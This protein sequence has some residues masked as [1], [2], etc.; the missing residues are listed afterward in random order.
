MG[1]G[2]CSDEERGGKRGSPGEPSKALA[3]SGMAGS[4]TF[5]Y[6]PTLGGCFDLHLRRRGVYKSTPL[7][8]IVN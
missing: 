6:V 5:H 3:I 1:L 8:A 2:N 4:H 7:K